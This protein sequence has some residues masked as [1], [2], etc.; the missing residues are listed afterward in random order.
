MDL[1]P[2]ATA[3]ELHI[4]GVGVAWGYCNDAKLT[5][6]R[7][8]NN[9][10]HPGK[11]YKTGDIARWTISGEVELVG[12]MDS[13]IKLRGVRIELGEIENAIRQWNGIRE[14][15]AV[16]REDSGSAVLV[17]YVS[18][19]RVDVIELRKYLTTKLPY[20]MVP[21]VIVP[22]QTIPTNS[23]GKIDLKALPSPSIAQTSSIAINAF[24]SSLLHIWQEVLGTPVSSTSMAF[25][26]MG[27][28]SLLAVQAAIRIRKEISPTFQTQH[29]LQNPTISQL[30]A[31][32]RGTESS[33]HESASYQATSDPG[34]KNDS[35]APR[36]TTTEG[37]QT[38]LNGIAVGLVAAFLLVGFSG[39]FLLFMMLCSLLP[40]PALY[41]S[42]LLF[43][44]MGMCFI[45]EH[46]ALKWSLIG[47]YTVGKIKVGSWAHARWRIVDYFSNLCADWF[48]P[49]IA[50]TRLIVYYYRLLGANIGKSV[51]INSVN[52]TGADLIQIGNNS[53]IEKDATLCSW[54]EDNNVLYQDRIRISNDCCVGESTIV[55]PGA[56]LSKEVFVAPFSIVPKGACLLSGTQWSGAVLQLQPATHNRV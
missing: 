48:L 16:I 33:P 46:I 39:A 18:P 45:I 54:T 27:G 38:Y 3:G 35:T 20:S 17:G 15:A 9:P 50:G 51:T 1:V 52:L 29:M 14:C 19:S 32:I 11:L 5:N 12:R 4:G 7:F 30:G 56:Q 23:N 8:L 25:Y 31:I 6:S 22:I 43:V 36:S 40:V 42:P 55:A 13:Q 37:K 49:L 10:Y 21:Q 24:E 44:I 53:L 28:T 34:P 47:K 41:A 2:V 26:D